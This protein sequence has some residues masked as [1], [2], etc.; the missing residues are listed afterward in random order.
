MH[1]SEYRVFAWSVKNLC[2]NGGGETV[3]CVY[4]WDDCHFSG[5]DPWKNNCQLLT[6]QNRTWKRLWLAA[7]SKNGAMHDHTCPNEKASRNPDKRVAT[8]RN[9]AVAYSVEYVTLVGN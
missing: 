3:S 7:V 8:S 9:V 5:S 6:N 2:L 4:S 1:R